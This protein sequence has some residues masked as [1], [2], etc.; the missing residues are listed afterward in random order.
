MRKADAEAIRTT[1]ALF[2]K[3]CSEHE[4]CLKCNFYKK[5]KGCIL[6][7]QPQFLDA[8]TIINCFT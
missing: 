4:R 8:E 7:C 6:D 1:I 5:G 3:E 2:K